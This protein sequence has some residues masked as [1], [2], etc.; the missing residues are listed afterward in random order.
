MMVPLVVIGNV[1]E[2]GTLNDSVFFKSQ[3]IFK[4][5]TLM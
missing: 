3:F 4:K 2:D 5:N 1:P